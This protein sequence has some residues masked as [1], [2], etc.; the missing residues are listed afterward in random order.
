MR[1]T[2]RGRSSEMT[3]GSGRTFALAAAAALLVRLALLSYG[4]RYIP[5]ISYY[6]QQAVAALASGSDPYGYSYSVPPQLLTPGAENVFAYLPG[7]LL[8]LFPFGVLTDVRL[9]L[10]ACDFIIAS[11]LAYSGGRKGLLAS[12]VFLFSPLVPFFSTWYPNNALVAMAFVAMSS[13]L[14]GRGRATTSAALLGLALASNQFVLLAYPF[15]AYRGLVSRRL[16][17]LAVALGVA[18]L[19]VLPFVAWDPAAFWGNVVAFPLTRPPTP[20]VVPE[21]FGYNV[22]LTLGGIVF[23][24]SGY[25]LP[26][27]LKGVLMSLPLV[28]LLRRSRRHGSEY[29]NAAIYLAVAVFIIPNTLSWWYLELPYLLL[30]I[31]LA[32]KGPETET[33][34]NP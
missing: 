11:C 26:L 8:M 6:D 3:W 27:W 16:G 7:V 29:L 4:F 20:L 14:S 32:R 25:V 15:L 22:N 18:G 34:L 13:V 24:L 17:E 5:D 23:T 12:V 19:V 30:L 33:A 1:F 31:W 28:L 21:A 2:R 10:V 9:G